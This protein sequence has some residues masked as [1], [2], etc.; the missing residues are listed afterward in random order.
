MSTKLPEHL[1][2]LALTAALDLLDEIGLEELQS[3]LREHPVEMQTAIDSYRDSAGEL[4]LAAEPLAP[5]PALKKKV[6]AGIDRL[7]QSENRAVIFEAP[8]IKALHPEA[9][10]WNRTPLPGISI[11]TLRDA[12]EDENRTLLVKMEPGTTYPTHR[13]KQREELF[14]IEGDLSLEGK[15][16][17]PGDYC[18]AEPESAHQTI[19][20]ASGAV[21]LVM[22]SKSDEFLGWRGAVQKLSRIF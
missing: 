7:I 1:Q 19:K 2:E 15:T 4:A 14:L 17:G 3:A 22:H 13:H 5:P 8:G 11:K 21:F 16:M 18:F 12:A 10:D 6:L 9:I 20:T